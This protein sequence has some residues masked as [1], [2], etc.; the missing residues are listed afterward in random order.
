MT[1]HQKVLL[2]LVELALKLHSDNGYVQPLI[3]EMI[4]HRPE[5]GETRA[6]TLYNDVAL[7]GMQYPCHQRMMPLSW[8]YR[9]DGSGSKQPV[10]S[11]VWQS[12]HQVAL[13]TSV[14]I[15][16]KCINSWT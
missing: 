1:C 7:F 9:V 2:G 15:V 14:N 10:Q 11:V 12:A 4:S 16:A 8:H 3:F 5:S 13:V 6:G